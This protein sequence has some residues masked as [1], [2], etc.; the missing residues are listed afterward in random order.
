M[1]DL[2]KRVL[3]LELKMNVIQ[4][5]LENLDDISFRKMNKDLQKEF[6][7]IH[8]FVEEHP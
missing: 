3:E 8:K 7:S 5:T 4:K 1:N 6:D 2:E